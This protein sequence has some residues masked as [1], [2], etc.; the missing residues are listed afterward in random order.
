[1]GTALR[2]V[3]SWSAPFTPSGRSPRR[4]FFDGA[5]SSVDNPI[6]VDILERNRV[7]CQT[8][9]D[10]TLDQIIPWKFHRW[11]AGSSTLPTYY[12]VAWSLSTAA[13]KPEKIGSAWLGRVRGKW[14]SARLY[15]ETWTTFDPEV[16]NR[17]L[18]PEAERR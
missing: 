10:T 13:S 6:H 9:G 5:G 12:V 14:Y 11:G 8:T 16:E 4:D 15:R 1:M 17:Q 2:P 18:L 7:Q 3:A